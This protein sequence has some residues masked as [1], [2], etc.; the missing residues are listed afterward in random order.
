MCL[1]PWTWHTS[2][3]Q[4]C[5]ASSFQHGED[6]PKTATASPAGIP[7]GSNVEHTW[8]LGSELTKRNQSAAD[9]HTRVWNK[10]LLQWTLRFCS[11][12]YTVKAGWQKIRV[13]AVPSGKQPLPW[14]S[15]GPLWSLPSN[16]Q[17]WVPGIDFYPN[18]DGLLLSQVFW[19]FLQEEMLSLAFS[20]SYASQ[21][22][23]LEFNMG[24]EVKGPAP[25]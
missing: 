2:F 1:R 10:C 9:T 16:R 24:E 17:D 19:P 13:R 6:T 25:P 12:Y 15:I 7:E 14:P 5:W 3:Y 21:P 11:L 8:A 22:N 23:S 20:S 4:P 18:K